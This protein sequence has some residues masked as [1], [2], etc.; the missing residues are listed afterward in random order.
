MYLLNY[1]MQCLSEAGMSIEN[2]G[3]YR[4]E[5]DEN[6]SRCLLGQKEHLGSSSNWRWSSESLSLFLHHDAG[7][8]SPTS[9]AKITFVA[10][11]TDCSE[12]SISSCVS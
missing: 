4:I 2:A 10:D 3:L 9:L 5:Q 1:E 11:E 8:L 12:H 7:L 6:C